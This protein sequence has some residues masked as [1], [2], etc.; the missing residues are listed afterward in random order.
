VENDTRS[1]L[2]RV[3]TGR[4]SFIDKLD[5][6]TN[7]VTEKLAMT[8]KM[9][10]MMLDGKFVSA[11]AILTHLLSLDKV[12]IT[13]TSMDAPATTKD[14]ESCVVSSGDCEGKN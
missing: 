12:M 14:F 8:E 5:V 2:M 6:V 4:G 10:E 9:S 1:V 3:L 13:V 7:L 11:D